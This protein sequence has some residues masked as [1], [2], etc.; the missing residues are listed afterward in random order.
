LCELGWKSLGVLELT[1]LPSIPKKVRA[2]TVREA[3]ALLVWGGDPTLEPETVYVGV[4]A[5]RMAM[6]SRFGEVYLDP[7]GCSGERISSEDIHFASSGGD[8][9]MTL[10]MAEGVG[11]V[12]FAIIPHVEYDDHQDVANAGTWAAQPPVPTYAIDDDTAIEVV[13]ATAE[14][15]SEG[16]W[17]FFAPRH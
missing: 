14:V 11:P 15:V 7:P 5:G 6:A 2:E 12:D 4:S 3:D 17:R 10:V 1:A 16:H 9:T 13:D 8:V